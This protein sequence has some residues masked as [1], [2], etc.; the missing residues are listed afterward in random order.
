MLERILV[1]GLDSA[2]PELVFDR[3]A[4]RLP[5][6][7]RLSERSRWGRLRSIDPPI[8]V[9]AW[10][11]MMSGQDA[12]RLGIYGFRNRAGYGY[13]Q[14]AIANSLSIRQPQ[15][16]D[17]LGA[18]GLDSIVVGAPP[19]YPARPLRGCRVGCFLTPKT[20]SQP[21][22]YP[23]ELA[24]E[25]DE[26]V[27]G[28]ET[29]VA[30]FRTDDREPL[31]GDIFRLSDKQFRAAAHLARTRPWQFLILV[32]IAVDRMHH[33]FWRYFD[34]EHRKHEP[35]NRFASAMLEFYQSVDRS[36]G[37]LLELAD[38]R[39]AVLVVSDH[40]AKRIDGGVCINDWLIRQGYLTLEE[41]P[42]QPTSLAKLKVNWR[43]TRAWGEGG[44]YGRVFVNLQGREPEGQVPRA[45]YEQFRDELAAGLAAIPDDQGRPMA[46]RVLK[47]QELYQ[48]VNGI[49][50]DLLVYFGD[51][52]WRSI[53]SVGYRAVHTLDNDS[54]PD[55]A[56]HALE[57]LYILS[58]PGVEPT[59]NRPQHLLQIA[60]TLLKLLGQPIPSD[61]RRPPF[62]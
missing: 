17:L 60:P 37:E 34:S 53:G 51:L 36:V 45:Q 41:Y 12:G 28:Y 54:G 3:F 6:L 27:G 1:I 56:N 40:G 39:T 43:K 24:H 2:D 61:M 20:P 31:L 47:P 52:H 33:G 32:N 57:G 14:L 44:Y 55:D 9:P 15:L 21:W 22:T 49:P 23:A 50:P 13:D 25:L 5:N 30:E 11:S 26:A 38:E 62:V 35:G 59:P 10:A 18:A 16:W 58:A 4:G 29:D 48:E 7:D 42:D 46:T 8:T 19:G